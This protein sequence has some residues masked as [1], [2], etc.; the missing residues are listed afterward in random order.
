MSNRIYYCHK[1]G[2]YAEADDDSDL[3]NLE[4]NDVGLFLT[5]YEFELMEIIIDD[6]PGAETCRYILAEC[7]KT[8]FLHDLA[9]RDGYRMKL[10]CPE[11]TRD[12]QQFIE[13]FL[14]LDAEDYE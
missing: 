13:E 9:G 5:E 7:W 2:V 12:A 1:N 8:I 14:K 10:D 3:L 11:L 6:N 4:I